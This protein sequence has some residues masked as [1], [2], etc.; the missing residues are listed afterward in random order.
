[1]IV[2]QVGLR[3]VDQR[4]RALRFQDARVDLAPRL[5]GSA[6]LRGSTPALLAPTGVHRGEHRLPDHVG[7]LGWQLNVDSHHPTAGLTPAREPAHVQ[8]RLRGIDASPAI[9]R[10]QTLDLRGRGVQGNVEKILLGLG[11]GDSRDC[12]NLRITDLS[13]RECLFDEMEFAERPRDANVLAGRRWADFDA[14]SQPRCR[15]YETRICPAVVRI[16]FTQMSEHRVGGQVDA[17]REC[18]DLLSERVQIFARQHLIAI[19]FFIIRADENE[20][21]EKAR[22]LDPVA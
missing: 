15:G 14:P 3:H 19:H 16:E 9:G 21:R 7:L 11:R 6:R 13:G 22:P 5:R 10:G 20:S 17:E 4:I 12:A 8:I 2:L 1:M 18:G